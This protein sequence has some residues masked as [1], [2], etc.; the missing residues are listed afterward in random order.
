[1]NTRPTKSTRPVRPA[2][3]PMPELDALDKTHRQVMVVLGELHQLIEHL[4]RSGVDAAARTMAQGICKFFAGSARQHHAD[5][6]RI[7]FPGLL[8]SP[9]ATLVQHVLRL[10]QDHGWLEEDWLEIEPQLQAVAEGYSW[11][12]LDTLRAALPIFEQLYRE[13]IALEESLIYPEAR[14]QRQL[15]DAASAARGTASS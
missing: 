5:E 6:E 3:P 1:M 12:D 14:R 9:D 11:Y 4:D 15:A 10:Q 2:A 7:V 13:H 8:K